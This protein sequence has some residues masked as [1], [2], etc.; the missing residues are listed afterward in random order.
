[1]IE[2]TTRLVRWIRFECMQGRCKHKHTWKKRE[3]NNK[4]FCIYIR[5]IFNRYSCLRRMCTYAS[6]WLYYIHWWNSPFKIRLA[7]KIKFYI[8]II[9]HPLTLLL[10]T[11]L[12]IICNVKKYDC[13]WRIS[14]LFLRPT[15]HTCAP[16]K[17]ST[18]YDF[19]KRPT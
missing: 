5:I 8:H 17:T 3:K 14:H 15:C 18:P 16:G 4:L 13:F 11:T 2:T 19:Q 12:F 9:F 1:M 10:L 7:K 6:L